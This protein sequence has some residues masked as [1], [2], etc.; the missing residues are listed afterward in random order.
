MCIPVN[1]VFEDAISEYT[2][3]KLL[4]SF[5]DKYYIG[6]SYQGN[7]FGYI[8][9]N[10]RGFNQAAI[11][12]PFFI[13]TDL[14][15]YV[16]PS[17]LIKDWLE[18]PLKPNLIFRIAVREVESWLLADIDGFSKFT[19]ISKVNI[20]DNPDNENDPK[21]T[22]VNLIKRSRKRYIKEDILPINEN[23]QIGPNYNERLM[24]YV[25]DYWD[26]NRAMLKSNSLYRAYQYLDNFKYTVPSK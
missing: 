21:K 11:A 17:E 18:Y 23:A 12:T 22:L 16:C 4:Q 25:S 2:M 8:K 3:V 1:L 15:T 9:T 13:L 26:L 6:Q 14:D 10:I 20:P 7:G 19:G 24:Q 5:G